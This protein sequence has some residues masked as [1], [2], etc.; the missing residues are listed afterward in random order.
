M[1]TRATASTL[2]VNRTVSP[3]PALMRKYSNEV[4]E[5]IAKKAHELYEQ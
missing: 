3:D 4:R 2:A 1:K 5:R